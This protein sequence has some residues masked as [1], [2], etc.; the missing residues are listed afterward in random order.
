MFTG[1]VETLAYITDL[2]SEPPGV[3]LVIA[4]GR[5]CRERAV[6]GDS[7]AVNGCCLTVVQIEGELLE[8]SGWR[9][10]IATHEFGGGCERIALSTSSGR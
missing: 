2:V 1:L 8:F 7:I 6:I 10:N 4:A 3:R 9:R 5:D